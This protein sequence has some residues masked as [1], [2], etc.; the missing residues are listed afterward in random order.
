MKC[1]SVKEEI[2]KTKTQPIFISDRLIIKEYIKVLLDKHYIHNSSTDYSFEDEYGELCH[3]ITFKIPNRVN[4]KIVI[5][6]QSNIDFYFNEDYENFDDCHKFW[7]F[8]KE[9]LNIH[10]ITNTNKR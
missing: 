7:W 1:E 6:N 2:F 10:P 9:S 3:E 4:G 5:Y 8:F